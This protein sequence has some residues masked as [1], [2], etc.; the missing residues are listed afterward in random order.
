MSLSSFEVIEIKE[1]IQVFCVTADSFPQ[2]IVP[3]HTKLHT[4]VPLNVNRQYFG[5]SWGGEQIT[6]KAAATEVLE[7]ELKDKGLEKFTIR[8]G[9]YLVTTAETPQDI[10]E[11]FPKLLQDPRV[12]PQ[13]YCVEKYLADNKI[14]C[15]V[16]LQD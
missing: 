13:G 10:Q 3:A 1:S 15:M 14:Q 9:K 4:V 6:Y 8:S 11:A 5:I 2:G 7:N 16:T 12:D